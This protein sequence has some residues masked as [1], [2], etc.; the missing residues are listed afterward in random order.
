MYGIITN[1]GIK[2]KHSVRHDY[3]HGVKL[4]HSVQHNNKHGNET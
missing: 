3:K 4:K 1:T 2:L